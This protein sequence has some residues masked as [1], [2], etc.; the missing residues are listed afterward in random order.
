MKTIKIKVKKVPT[1]RYEQVRKFNGLPFRF[2]ERNLTKVDA[3]R[4]R[5]A[6]MYKGNK[7]RIIETSLG[8]EVWAYPK[9]RK[10]RRV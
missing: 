4:T 10:V 6:L 1:K 7:V 5:D 2:L 9:T 3:R 8:F